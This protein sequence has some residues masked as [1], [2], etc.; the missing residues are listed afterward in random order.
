MMVKRVTKQLVPW[1]WRRRFRERYVAMN[2][3]L[4]HGPGNIRLRPNECVVTCVVRNGEFY[5]ERFI[6]H[7]SNMGFRHL[8]LLDNGSTDNT[9]AIAKKHKNVSIYTSELPIEAHQAIFKKHL[10]KLCAK[11]GW[12][13]DADIDEF[14]DFPCSDSISLSQLLDYLNLNGYTAVITQLLD[15]FS[16]QRITVSAPEDEDPGEA[17]SVRYAYYD[18]SEVTKTTYRTSELSATYGGRNRISN[19]AA[20]LYW[21]GIRKT[22]SGNEYLLTKHSLFCMEPRPELFPHVHFVDNA[23]VADVSGVLLHYKLTSS[24]L[25]IALQNKERFPGN[26]KLYSDFIDYITKNADYQVNRPG[27]TRLTNV[28]ELVDNTFLFTS[29]KFRQY[30]ESASRNR[31]SVGG[32]ELRLQKHHLPRQ[33]SL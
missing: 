21:G 16:D 7:Y 33:V 22:L 9:V 10:P 19:E 4:L 32:S 24:A 12:C 26:G 23:A 31:S 11:G 17:L 30:V 8:F 18:L 27:A 14:F 2:T 6:Q 1:K 29:Q 25:A 28:N 20:A 5:L 15:M 3:S 13:L